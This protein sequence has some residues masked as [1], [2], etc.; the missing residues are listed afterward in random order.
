MIT[1]LFS[2][3]E[4]IQS[5]ALENVASRVRWLKKKRDLHS[6]MF[7]CF[8]ASHSCSCCEVTPSTIRQTSRRCAWWRRISATWDTTSSRNRSSPWRP[9]YWWRP[10]RSVLCDSGKN[11]MN[12]FNARL[13]SKKVL[14]ACSVKVSFLLRRSKVTVCGAE[15]F[16]AGVFSMWFHR[17]P[18]GTR[19]CY[20]FPW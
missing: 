12:H 18:T 8:L 4:H 7:V 17:L 13:H 11:F 2:F 19:K 15:V 20:A 14:T 5:P 6:D 1:F 16:L 10:T 3:L 9:P